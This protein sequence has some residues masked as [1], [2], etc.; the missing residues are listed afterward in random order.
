MIRMAGFIAVS[1]ADT[2]L[3]DYTAAESVKN[4]SFVELDHKEKTGA[5]ADA[6]AP[7]AY[8]ISNEIDTVIE[9]GIDDIDYEVKKGEF[10]R[11]HRPQVGEILVTTEIDEDLAEGDAADVVAGGKV[12]QNDD[13][14][15]IVKELTNEYGVQTARLLVINHTVGGADEGTEEEEG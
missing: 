2:F 12:G 6:G 10:L 8:F 9:E 11:A 1:L 13:G 4:G 14:R 15:Y 5:L 7:E 3:G